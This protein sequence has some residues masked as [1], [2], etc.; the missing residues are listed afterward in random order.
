MPR[1]IVRWMIAAFSLLAFLAAPGFSQEAPAVKVS[2]KGASQPAN[3]ELLVG[4]SRV[5]QLDE[6]SD[7]SQYSMAGVITVLPLTPRILV[8]NGVSLGQVNLVILR[9]KNSENDS[10]QM[11]V[12]N[13]FVQKN[14]SLID[15]SIRILYPKENIQLS[16]LND[17]VVISGSVT[18][19]EIAD[20]VEKVLKGA[21]VKYINL[22]KKPP[23]MQQQVQMQ[24]RIAE[25]DRNIL[26]QLGAAFGIMNRT[27]P[28]YINAA[29]PA[30]VSVTGG[31]SQSVV[32]ILNGTG[33]NIFLGR[34][35]L[36]SAFIQAVQQRAAVRSLAEPN[37]I[38]VNGQKGRFHS[39]GKIP[40]PQIA[41]SNGTTGYSITYTEYGVK[42]DFT[43]TITDE[44]HIRIQLDTEVSTPDSVNGI[45]SGD[46]IIPGIRTNS[47]STTLELADG[48]SFAL[49][50][51]L[52]N[53]EDV[54]TNQIPLLGDIPVLGA[55]FKSKQFQRK[56]TELVFLCTVKL[57]EPLNPDQVPRLP[58]TT[59]SSSPVQGSPNELKP[60]SP[61]PLQGQIQG[62]KLPAIGPG[63]LPEGD[64]GHAV[65]GKSA[66]GNSPIQ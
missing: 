43:P 25:V 22:L 15:N 40:I 56:E 46:L 49:A 54:T 34:P 21:E 45:R 19:P 12:L 14:L 9:K 37:I 39:G 58:G 7:A 47:A 11:V 28:S 52:N 50:G 8:V 4:Q 26:R 59:Q 64:T 32:S 31:L 62:Q 24:V 38:A 60:L 41:T 13:V 16:Q 1:R 65:P 5:I 2:F 42:I 63:I 61:K 44:N 36:T 6:D 3:L 55:L 27:I 20:E 33:T 51:L 10:P 35:D 30:S 66:K 17:S 57:S 18:R 29:G 53:S 23:V 48:Q